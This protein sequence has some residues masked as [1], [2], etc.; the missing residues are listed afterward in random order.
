MQ[1]H[2]F[3]KYFY[4]VH[5]IATKWV[6]FESSQQGEHFYRSRIDLGLL[7]FFKKIKKFFEVALEKC[8][9]LFQLFTEQLETYNTEGT[10]NR[11]HFYQRVFLIPS[12]TKKIHFIQNRGHNSL[13]SEIFS[14]IWFASYLLSYV[15]SSKTHILLPISSETLSSEAYLDP[16]WLVFHSRDQPIR[17]KHPLCRMVPLLMCILITLAVKHISQLWAFSLSKQEMLFNLETPK[18]VK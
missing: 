1:F 13:C 15:R 10:C 8:Y 9:V 17:I 3:T 16:S 5:P 11:K 2:C 12:I 18:I 4:I 14:K 7:H 6:S